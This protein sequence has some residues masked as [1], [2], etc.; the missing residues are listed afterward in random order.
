NLAGTITASNTF[1][2]FS[3]NICS[4]AF[5]ALSPANPGPNL[6]W[7]TN[8]LSSDGTLRVL[9]TIPIAIIK[10]LSTN[11]LTLSWPADH[12]GWRLQVQT[13]SIM[14]TN[15]VNVPNSTGTN[16]INLSVN[17]AG[18]SAFYRLHYP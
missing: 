18:P 12:I 6:A 1:K 13:N 14:D 9:S 8:T 16:Q 10:T 3:A 15:W 17:L 2:L 5:A 4:G 7:N 11:L